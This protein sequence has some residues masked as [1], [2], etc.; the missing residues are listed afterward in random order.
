MGAASSLAGGIFS[1][2]YIVFAIRTLGLTPAMLGLTVT[3]GGLGG[4][5]G[6]A[7]TPWLG[8]RLGMGHAILLSAWLAAAFTTLI[9]FAGGSPVMAMLVLMAA[10]VFGDAAG[11]AEQILQA[12][13]RQ[14]ILPPVTLGRTAGAFAAVNGLA[15]TLGAIG[16]GFLGTALGLRPAMMISSAGLLLAPAFGLARGLRRYDG[17]PPDSVTSA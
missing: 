6:A 8:R 9:P 7:M 15:L 5:A 17:A 4:L 2:T 3:M 1:A 13:A 12:S 11:T 14:S 10:Q 16:G